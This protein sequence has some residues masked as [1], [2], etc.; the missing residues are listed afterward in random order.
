MTSDEPD[1]EA[2]DARV[3]RLIARFERERLCP[4]RAA[5]SLLMRGAELTRDALGKEL[6]VEILES[7][8]EAVRGSAAPTGTAH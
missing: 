2:A 7:L 5:K 3:L 6:T 1:F 8:I 4:C